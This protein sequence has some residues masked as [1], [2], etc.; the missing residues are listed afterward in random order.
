[1]ENE[2]NFDDTETH[3]FMN[4]AD[5]IVKLTKEV[6]A[7]KS[8]VNST[9]MSDT[10][11]GSQSSS[12]N[13]LDIN[14]AVAYINEMLK[15][16][17]DNIISELKAEFFRL[18]N[19]LSSFQTM[20]QYPRSRNSLGIEES[21]LQRE[22]TEEN[23][24]NIQET[25]EKEKGM[26]KLLL[27][28]RES[29][30]YELSDQIVTIETEKKELQEKYDQ[31]LTDEGKWSKQKEVLERLVTSDPRF[32]IINLL[33]RM[34]VIA[35]IQLSFVLG[36]SLSQ[37]KRYINELEKMKILQINE[38]NTVSLDTSFDEETMNIKI[39]TSE[40]K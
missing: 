23:I 13:L 29:L 39:K 26:L 4:I 19:F 20:S 5:E 12:N 32:N 40:D 25:I 37:T 8:K 16:S 34:G 18:F 15:S 22:L 2:E 28:E 30:I 24:A 1:M 6:K 27:E 14:P 31:I 3:E 33:R 38:D 11:S 10:K 17:S 9:Q 7:I 21:I 36:V 35:P